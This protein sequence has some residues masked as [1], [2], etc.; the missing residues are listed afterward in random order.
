M[1]EGI[2]VPIKAEKKIKVPEELEGI[3]LK[4][5]SPDTDFVNAMLESKKAAE[6]GVIRLTNKEVIL[7]FV[8]K[9]GTRNAELCDAIRA[10]Y[11]ITDIF[12]D[13]FGH[14]V[15]N[16]KFGIQIKRKYPNG[17]TR[18]IGVP[19]ELRDEVN[20]I[21]VLKP[22]TPFEI[23]CTEKKTGNII[24][25]EYSQKLDDVFYHSLPIDDGRYPTNLETGI[26][27][28]D[29]AGQVMHLSR[30]NNDSAVGGVVRWL[31]SDYY[32]DVYLL[33]LRD[34]N[35]RGVLGKIVEK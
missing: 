10:E 4:L 18:I 19:P 34:D 16:E 33:D 11:G 29:G 26:P 5:I 9:D 7:L 31:S 21:I 8:N 32:D 14:G 1:A 2:L 25:I 27:S 13:I 23:H 12:T 17:E 28:K 22:A 35:A 20:M 6:E 30:W 15:P 24:A 3:R